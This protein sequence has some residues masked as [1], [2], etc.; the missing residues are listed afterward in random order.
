MAESLLIYRSP[1]AALLPVVTVGLVASI[2]P[3]LIALAAQAFDL[4][5]D[6]SLQT[7]LLV[8]LYGIGT[9]Y[10]LF[11]LFRYRERLREGD[12]KKQAM[13]FAV[14]RVGEVIASAAGV[15][16]VASWPC[17]WRPWA[18]S[19]RSGRPWRSPSP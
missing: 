16:I 5:V 14:A 3:G 12:D 10:I 18:S 13:V 9:D 8:V 7:I 19:P 1:V 6:P 4:Q 11:L 15:V 2:A 17:C